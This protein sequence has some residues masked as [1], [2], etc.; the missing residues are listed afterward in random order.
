MSIRQS[1]T[2][3]TFEAINLLLMLGISIAMLYPFYYMFIVSISDNVSVM[4][5]QVKWLPVNWSFRAYAAVFKDPL[6]LRGFLN[7]FTYMIVGT[8]LNMLMTALCAYPLSRHDLYGRNMFM[9]MIV[10]TM[11]FSGGL[12]PLFLLV[13]NLGLI[14][15]IGA[16]VLPGAISVFNMIIMRSFFQSIP[17][18]LTESAHID[19]ANDVYVFAKIIL[20]LSM[21]IVATLILFYAVAQWNAFLGPLMFLT[22]KAHYPIQL[23]VRNI[24]I[25]GQTADIGMAINE[26]AV[27]G[28]TAE[29]SIKYAIILAAAAPVMLIYPFIIKY[30]EKGVMV[31]SV[32]G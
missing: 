8:A 13:S 32:K 20:P 19:G 14:N 3:K 7:S 16:V 17:F 6:I 9:K 23:F 24:V 26:T 15:S 29:K 22:E 5:N 25:E 10:F 27:A 2:E 30:F 31:G 28:A 1:W 11:F 21:P 12:I 4:T 18:A